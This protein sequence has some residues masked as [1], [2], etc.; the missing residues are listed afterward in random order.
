MPHSESKTLPDSGNEKTHKAA[1]LF[2]PVQLRDAINTNRLDSLAAPKV[3]T[4]FMNMRHR[5]QGILR[6]DSALLI[7]LSDNTFHITEHVLY[8]EMWERDTRG[9]I[10]FR[11]NRSTCEPQHAFLRARKVISFERPVS[12]VLVS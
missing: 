3:I 10:N 2:Y 6:Q 12:G 8:Q 9:N 5:S 1:A 11:G 7:T 4:P